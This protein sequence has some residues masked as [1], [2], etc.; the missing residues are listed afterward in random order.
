MKCPHCGGYASDNA[1]FCNNCGDQIRKR[2]S[3]NIV[4]AVKLF[5]ARYVDFSGRSRRSE[6]WWMFLVNNLV[7]RLLNE[8]G[9]TSLTYIWSLV[10]FIPMLALC[11]RRLHD[12]G[13]SGWWYLFTFLPV[14]GW[15]VLLVFFCK[16]SAPDNQWGDNPKK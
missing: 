2:S 9:L 5:F 8:V 16:D 7:I 15:I 11:V 10:I 1:M 4:E 3:V 13:K 12:V 6:Y 14:V